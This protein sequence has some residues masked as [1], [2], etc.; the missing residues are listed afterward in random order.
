MSE[1]YLTPA[2]AA[3]ALGVHVVTIRRWTESGRLEAIRTPGGHRRIPHAEILRLR[4]AHELAH[5]SPSVEM[6]AT[7]QPVAADRAWADHALIHARYELQTHGDEQWMMRLSEEARAHSRESGR[8]LMGLLLQYIAGSTPDPDP[9]LWHEVHE[10][11]GGYAVQMRRSGLSLTQ[12]TRAILF[13]R[14]VLMQSTAYYPHLHE[15]GTEQHV[16]LMR[17]LSRF[18]N[19]IQLVITGVYEDRSLDQP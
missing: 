12:A 4:D 18:M 9:A 5:A 1:Q 3:E 15:Q 14:D 17:K 7:P 13:F 11:A 16:E 19:E 8:R 6:S 2:E 10:L